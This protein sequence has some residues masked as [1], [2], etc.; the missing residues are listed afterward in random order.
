[1]TLSVRIGR[2]ATRKAQFA[3]RCSRIKWN[4]R[5]R[6]LSTLEVPAGAKHV[7]EFDDELARFGERT[8]V[9]SSGVSLNHSK[10]PPPRCPGQRPPR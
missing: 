10:S 7:S 3:F 6:F 2:K 4:S 5:K 1:M 8:F 9:S